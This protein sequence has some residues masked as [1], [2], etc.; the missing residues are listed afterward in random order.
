VEI[1]ILRGVFF[2]RITAYHCQYQRPKK[3]S[4]FR[5]PPLKRVA[6]TYVKMEIEMENGR[7]GAG[8]CPAFLLVPGKP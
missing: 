4:L 1:N 5:A 8:P 3:S 2:V 6:E 7:K